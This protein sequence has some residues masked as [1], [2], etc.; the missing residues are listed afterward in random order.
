MFVSSST[1]SPSSS[2]SSATPMHGIVGPILI[3]LV[4]TS[5]V[6]LLGYLSMVLDIV[7]YVE[8]RGIKKFCGNV[9]LP[10]IFF[11]EVSNVNWGTVDLGIL[12][13]MFSGKVI[14]FLATGI[15]VC[16]RQGW[17][18]K[19]S[20]HFLSTMGLFC[21]FSTKSNDIALGVPLI[22]AAFSTNQVKFSKYLYLFAPFQ[23][24]VLNVVGFVLLE[25]GRQKN[26][27]SQEAEQARLKERYNST[28]S[29]STSTSS[30]S[31]KLSPPIHQQSIIYLVPRILWNVMTTPAVFSVIIG[32]ITNIIL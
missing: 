30:A 14:T 29:T 26:E 4:Q 27:L 11:V 22:D 28:N 12:M 18:P 20:E 23:L 10:A 1:P 19:G 15:Y 9:A 25:L 8:L 17:T 13:G 7:T 31:N 16:M 21:I 5:L 2:S 6:I 32:L 24:L 3:A